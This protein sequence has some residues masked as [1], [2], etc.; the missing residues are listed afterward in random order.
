[1]TRRGCAALPRFPRPSATDGGAAAA[2]TV[3]VDDAS[4]AIRTTSAVT[5]HRAAPREH[6]TGLTAAPP[7]RL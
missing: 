2:P 5:S 1:M 3:V 4:A 6:A 7:H